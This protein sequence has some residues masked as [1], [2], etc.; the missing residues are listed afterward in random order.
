MELSW[1]SP[2]YSRPS[3]D[4]LYAHYARIAEDVDLPLVLY[5]VPAEPVEI[6][7]RRQVERLARL[8]NIVAIKEASGSLDQASDIPPPRTS[9][10]VLSGDDS[11]TLPMLAIGA[12]G[13]VSVAANLVPREIMAV[14]EAYEKRAC[15]DRTTSSTWISFL[16]AGL[17]WISLLIPS[18][19]RRLW[20]WWDAG[21]ASYGCHS[22]R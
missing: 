21:A 20:K 1:S 7:T 19:S 9:L 12:E 4:G 17:S 10:T 18:H 6:S 2:Y 14:I 13:V 16:S 5:N 8:W 15:C 11:L 22:L 3:Q